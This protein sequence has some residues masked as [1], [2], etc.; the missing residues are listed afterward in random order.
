M[1]RPVVEWEKEKMVHGLPRI[2]TVWIVDSNA[3][4]HLGSIASEDAIR[5]M[6]GALAPHGGVMHVTSGVDDE[7]KTV[8][9]RSW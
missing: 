7:V 8:R 6:G 5:S 1:A 4:I 3:F 9:F 2:M